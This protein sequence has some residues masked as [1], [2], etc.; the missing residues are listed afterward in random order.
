MAETVTEHR[1]GF[2]S[3]RYQFEK[4]GKSK[5][6][7]IPQLTDPL[8]EV[9]KKLTEALREEPAIQEVVAAVR[10]GRES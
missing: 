9:A 5:G 6:V 2:V 1:N 7:K 3:L 10:T 8:H 4:L